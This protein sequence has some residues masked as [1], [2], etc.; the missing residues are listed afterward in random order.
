M[1]KM[2]L[3]LSEQIQEGKINEQEAFTMMGISLGVIGSR[4]DMMDKLMQSRSTA[5]RRLEKFRETSWIS[6][7]DNRVTK[8]F[9]GWEFSSSDCP[10]MSH[11]IVDDAGEKTTTYIQTDT[12][13]CSL[14][15]ENP[16]KYIEE[17][18]RNERLSKIERLATE[19]V[20]ILNKSNRLEKKLD[21]YD[22]F[23]HIDYIL[24]NQDLTEKVE[25]FVLNTAD[26]ALR[27]YDS[28]HLRPVA[29][30]GKP[31]LVENLPAY[32][33][34]TLRK[35]IDNIKYFGP[36]RRK[37]GQKNATDL[38]LVKKE[39]GGYHAQKME[40]Y[41]NDIL[42]FNTDP[43]WKRA[44]SALFEAAEIEYCERPGQ[45]VNFIKGIKTLLEVG[46]FELSGTEYAVDHQILKQ[47]VG[48]SAPNVQYLKKCYQTVV[49]QKA[50]VAPKET[51]TKWQSGIDFSMFREN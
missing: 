5:G 47:A 43:E 8:V 39:P 4:E 42:Q 40:Q 44:F 2:Y 25:E 34:G 45:C 29:E 27:H 11:S 31:I 23:S 10:K 50:K 51:K 6:T 41:K 21:K 13:F 30:D 3:Q 12:G 14:E 32:F 26:Y 19:T 7:E 37:K 35:R 9:F 33:A 46:R 36:S 28:P 16:T 38:E 24:L 22:V 15:D 17:S 1:L 48:M 20:S 18:S 49:E